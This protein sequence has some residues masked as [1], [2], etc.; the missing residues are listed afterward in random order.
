MSKKVRRSGSVLSL[1][2]ASFTW[3][4]HVFSKLIFSYSAYLFLKCKLC[5]VFYCLCYSSLLTLLVLLTL[6]SEEGVQVVYSFWYAV[7]YFTLLNKYGFDFILCCNNCYIAVL[8]VLLESEL[9]KN[10]NLIFKSFRAHHYAYE[11]KVFL[12]PWISVYI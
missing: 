7:Q 11:V 6:L 1:T 8:T 3:C 10:W 9:L 5:L 12:P 4:L 2:M